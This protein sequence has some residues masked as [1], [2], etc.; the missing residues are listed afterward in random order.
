MATQSTLP[1]SNPE[2][3]GNRPPNPSLENSLRH[4]GRAVAFHL[5]NDRENA[6]KSLEVAEKAGGH[7]AEILAARG[8]IF[9]ELNRF[10]EAADNYKRLAVLRPASAEIQPALSRCGIRR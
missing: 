9:F 8:Q 6:L 1:T 10:E 2:I 4:L 7:P 5:K 3:A